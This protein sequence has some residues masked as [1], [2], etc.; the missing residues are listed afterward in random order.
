ML[1]GDSIFSLKSLTSYTKDKLKFAKV[2]QFKYKI[3]LKVKS[4]V[5]RVCTMLVPASNN[6]AQRSLMLIDYLSPRYKL[7]VEL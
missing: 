1:T 3:T 6:I 2:D 7:P 5:N 4:I